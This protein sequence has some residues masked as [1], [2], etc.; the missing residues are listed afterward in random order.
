MFAGVR[1]PEL[2]EPDHRQN[3]GAGIG[4]VPPGLVRAGCRLCGQGSLT[5]LQQQMQT[6]SNGITTRDRMSVGYK[7]GLLGTGLW[8]TTMGTVVSSSV[9]TVVTVVV[10]TVVTVVVMVTVVGTVVFVVIVVV[11][12]LVVVLLVLTVVGIGVVVVL[13]VVL[14]VLTVVGVGVVVV[15]V[16]VLLVLTVVG[17]VITV[18]V[19]GTAGGSTVSCCTGHTCQSPGV[20]LDDLFP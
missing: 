3:H 7:R 12:V 4:L 10:T 16:V 19:V 17:T 1:T 8:V 20:G 5:L 14:L 2:M 9:T 13:V 15:L 11:V 18:V 6:S